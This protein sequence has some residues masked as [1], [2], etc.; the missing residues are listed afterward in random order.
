MKFQPGNFSVVSGSPLVCSADS[1]LF[2]VDPI[3]TNSTYDWT[4]AGNIT[5]VKNA[6]ASG[7]SVYVFFDSSTQDFEKGKL[8]VK[9]TSDL[10]CKTLDK[11]ATSFEFD[12]TTTP[13]KLDSI[14]FAGSK[15]ICDGSTINF[16]AHGGKT[17]FG[18]VWNTDYTA[19]TNLLNAA[20]SINTVLA[21]F[22]LQTQIDTLTNI[23]VAQDNKGC[24]GD[25][26]AVNFTIQPN[27]DKVEFATE[28]SLC[29]QTE[30][31]I[32]VIRKDTSSVL[33]WKVG[34]FTIPNYTAD[35][36]RY[37]ITDDVKFTVTE[38]NSKGCVTTQTKSIKL[39]AQPKDF[40]IL[41]NKPLFCSTDTTILFYVD[42]KDYE[43]STTYSW[44]Y[45]GGISDVIFDTNNKD[46]VFVKFQ[47]I[48]LDT[49]PSSLTVTATNK[50][51]CT[52]LIDDVIVKDF[53]VTKTPTKLSKIDFSGLFCDTEGGKFT[54]VG[55]NASY[56]Y[57]WSTDFTATTTLDTS[58]HDNPIDVTFALNNT[59]DSLS[60]IKV[61]QNNG[62]CIGDTIT[63]KI[64]IHKNPSDVIIAG[65]DKVCSFTTGQLFVI[66]NN[67]QATF[68]WSTTNFLDLAKDT[69]SYK[70]A[71]TSVTF[72]VVQKNQFGCTAEQQKTIDI[73]DQP[74]PFEVT[75]QALICSADSALF[76]VNPI[77]ATSSYEWSFKQ[78]DVIKK[79]S[80]VNTENNQVYV[81]FNTD[82]N[83]DSITSYLYVKQISDNGCKT[84]DK[85][86]IIDTLNVITTPDT[87]DAITFDP[88]ICNTGDKEFTAVGGKAN[89]DFLWSTDF[90]TT[91]TVDATK[92]AKTTVKF[93]LPQGDII[94]N[95]KVAQELAGCIGDTI[96]LAVTVN[97]LPIV[98]EINGDDIVCVK[99]DVLTM[100]I[101]VDPLW[102]VTWGV[103]DK[104]LTDNSYVT[105]INASTDDTIMYIIN[106]YNDFTKSAQFFASVIDEKGCKSAKSSI[107]TVNTDI[108]LQ[109]LLG[110]VSIQ[111]QD[112][113][114]DIQDSRKTWTF[115]FDPKISTISSLNWDVFNTPNEFSNGN[116]FI[117]TKK[118]PDGTYSTDSTSIN[119]KIDGEGYFT[120]QVSPK[121]KNC[122]N[123]PKP[124]EFDFWTEKSKLVSFSLPEK[125][126]CVGDSNTFFA[127][128]NI[129]EN[130]SAIS[131]KEKTKLL[132]KIDYQWNFFNAI[133]DTIASTD[134][135]LIEAYYDNQL[136][137][138]TLVYNYKDLSF[139]ELANNDTIVY[140]KSIQKGD[141]LNLS[142]EPK[143]CAIDDNFATQGWS[144]TKI[145]TVIDYPV[146]DI[147]ITAVGAQQEDLLDKVTVNDDGY[148]VIDDVISLQLEGINL[149]KN[150]T[151]NYKFDYKWSYFNP[152]VDS[153]ENKLLKN[154]D[155]IVSLYQNPLELKETKIYFEVAYKEGYCKYVDEAIVLNNFVTFI[156]N[157]FSP[158]GDGTFDTWVIRNIDK[159]PDATGQIFNRWGALVYEGPMTTEGWKGQTND[160][161]DLPMGTYFYIVKY[162]ADSEA[163]AGSVT[164]MR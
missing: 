3:I 2:T 72:T 101:D 73:K 117:E 53:N 88:F 15:Y 111:G 26:L 158:N 69:I 107:H 36:L 61:A 14:T 38:T 55:G 97:P 93:N 32:K 96:T 52:T 100:S 116:G 43:D 109:D 91:T 8:T 22:T 7:D 108:A 146:G 49:I 18:Y 35:S 92:D 21:R 39:K 119:V 159:H 98:P 59:S 74:D 67:P 114:C 27:P 83:R 4:F 82:F 156:P 120:V 118:L 29:T 103:V 24:I 45:K 151:A 153:A 41:S 75:G 10:G 128:V 6:T 138:D 136:Q 139:F 57:L 85:D 122:K 150:D 70:F 34:N 152:E 65:V 149:E 141:Y 125:P 56:K 164:I 112:S 157:V 48:V 79:V 131:D 54:A 62:G 102:D 155:Q 110:A 28:D 37:V 68:D 147:N 20:D 80:S 129:L 161:K 19:T 47:N 133:N 63:E 113:I 154:H 135:V 58:F 132:T 33:S 137:K 25:S 163:L 30:K 42:P 127:E 23:K 160:E 84:L 89:Y 66:K 64:T 106:E 51:G 16:T 124:Y 144:Q 162:S 40:E 76:T 90:T 121:N 99:Y 87:L 104:T 105:R 94:S 95:V 9:Q 130:N 50:Q 17:H 60:N 123:N 12:I 148:F 5:N 11:D 86:V 115:T 1:A 71:D 44:E 46:S 143:F 31:I 140:D 126:T 81:H 13:E 145:L 134:S 142:I 78:D 77:V